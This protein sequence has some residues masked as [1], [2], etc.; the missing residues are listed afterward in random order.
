MSYGRR[1]PGTSTTP[2]PPPS[3]GH[4]GGGTGVAAANPNLTPQQMQFET[5][6]LG[7]AIWEKLKKLERKLANIERALDTAPSQF[8]KK[9]NIDGK[10][11]DLLGPG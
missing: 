3:T 8:G 4:G 11:I 1:A 10:G 5:Y 6:R 2:P 7:L 9:V